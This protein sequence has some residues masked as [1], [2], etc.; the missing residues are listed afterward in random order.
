M[1]IY[2]S[3]YWNLIEEIV[4]LG[5]FWMA[6]NAQHIIGAQ[7][8]FKWNLRN[9]GF[10]PVFKKISREDNQRYSQERRENEFK[11]MY[12][13]DKAHYLSFCSSQN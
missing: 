1:L 7:E 5:I 13:G 2:V 12:L 3:L 9:M 10:Y 4:S 8:L 6:L 11:M